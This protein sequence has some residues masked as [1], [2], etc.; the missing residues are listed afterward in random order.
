[1]RQK[2]L[3]NSK[4]I[5][6]IGREALLSLVDWVHKIRRQQ[7]ERAISGDSG[8]PDDHPGGTQTSHHDAIGADDS[9]AAHSEPPRQHG[10]RGE[11][12]A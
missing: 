1:M 2:A 12:G 9:P 7:H 4:D 11:E 8:V 5:P 3:T 6:I 10:V